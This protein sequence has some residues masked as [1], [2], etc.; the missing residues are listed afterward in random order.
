MWSE[1]SC[2]HTILAKIGLMSLMLISLGGLTRLAAADVLLSKPE[3]V[4]YVTAS[5]VKD[6]LPGETEIFLNIRVVLTDEVKPF[7]D[8]ISRWYKEFGKELRLTTEETKYSLGL[9]VIP[10]IIRVAKLGRIRE[11]QSRME[12]VNPDTDFCHFE[13]HI[14]NNKAHTILTGIFLLDPKVAELNMSC[15]ETSIARL[16]GFSQSIRDFAN[17]GQASAAVD[18]LSSMWRAQLKA[19]TARQ[20]CSHFIGSSAFDGCVRQEIFSER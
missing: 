5:S 12:N 18:D 7:T 1:R 2:A 15:F 10:D 11:I 9:V 13:Y 20:A 16:Y 8:F 3:L 17:R 4:Q 6:A 19:I 14:E